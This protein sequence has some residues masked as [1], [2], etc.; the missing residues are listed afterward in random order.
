MKH[1]RGDRRQNL[2][3]IS[4]HLHAALTS[5]T[6]VLIGVVFAAP[7]ANA[8]SS[9]YYT[10]NVDGILKEAGSMTESSSPYFW[11][12]SGGE[13]RIKSG[14]GSTILGALP[15]GSYWLLRYFSANALDTDGGK[16]PQNIFRLVT[17][18]KWDNLTEEV[19][20]KI[21]KINTTDTPNRDGYSGILLM[22]HYQDENNL[23]YAGVRMDGSA[24]I[25]KKKGG[26]YTT[27]AQKNGVFPGTYN[28]TS[29]PNL[30]PEDR[31]MKLKSETK[32]LADGME[33]TLWLDRTD[34][35]VWEK[36]LTVVDSV[37]PV[38]GP[39]SAGIRTDY[40][41]VYFDNYKLIEN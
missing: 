27:L 24:V 36:L 6:I 18:N 8:A 17:K 22:S 7:T 39:A 35:G 31:W 19:K 16:Y 28:K 15:S 12:N 21:A 14:A 37:N 5:L 9:F 25:K 33:I 29:N 13:V 20:F 3:A 10:F 32:P 1:H 23:Y 11:L 26:V 40:M 30:I 2:T 4:M 34:T 41:D 38:T